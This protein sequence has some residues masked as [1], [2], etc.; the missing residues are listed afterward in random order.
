[1]S[2]ERLPLNTADFANTRLDDGDVV[3][4]GGAIDQYDNR[5]EV[6]G[7]VFRPGYYAINDEVKTLRDLIKIA[8]GY[9]LATQP[10]GYRFYAILYPAQSR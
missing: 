9:L 6:R 2:L 7:A 4:V 5:V 10:Q 8:N 3:N 1:M